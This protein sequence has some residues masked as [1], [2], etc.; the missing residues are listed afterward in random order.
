MEHG[1]L[2]SWSEHRQNMVRTRSKQGQHKKVDHVPNMKHGQLG[3]WSEHGQNKVKITWS[4]NGVDHVPNMVNR[5]LTMEHCHQFGGVVLRLKVTFQTKL[6][7]HR[8]ESQALGHRCGTIYSQFLFSR[9][10]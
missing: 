7:H 8:T 10:L 9:V 6:I 5:V 1:Q 4:E 3:T 2:G